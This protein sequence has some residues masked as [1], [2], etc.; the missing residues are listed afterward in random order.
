VNPSLSTKV[1]TERLVL[2]PPRPSDIPALRRLLIENAEHLRPWS[3]AAAAGHDPLSLVEMTRSITR[4]R[5]LWREDRAYTLLIERREPEGRLVGRVVL[6][7]VVRGAFENA[8]LGY[9]IDR[10]HQGAGL[11]SEAVQAVVRF[12]FDELR[13]HRVQAAV[14]PKNVGSRRVLA[15]AGFREEGLALRYLQIAGSW[16]DHVLHAITSDLRSGVVGRSR[17]RCPRQGYAP[18][19]AAGLRAL[20]RGREPRVCDPWFSALS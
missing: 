7:E 9:W 1:L 6:S 4:Q 5:R 10:N 19:T 16:Q 2:R 15:K 3:P 18:C 20:H 13:L 8:Y 17:G 12:A 14:I 11:M